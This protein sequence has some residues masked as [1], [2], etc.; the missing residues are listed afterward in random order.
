M[1]GGSSSMA[2]ITS[3]WIALN[4]AL[5]RHFKDT[6]YNIVIQKNEVT[7]IKPI[8][9]DCQSVTAIKNRSEID[10]LVKSIHRFKKSRITASSD[11]KEN[12]IT[13]CKSLSTHA[14]LLK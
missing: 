13:K 10:K 6:D 2:S 5:K 11:I 7:Y 14:V 1:F 4:E 3:G 12:G 9:S 8:Y